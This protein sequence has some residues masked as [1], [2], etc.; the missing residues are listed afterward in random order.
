[1]LVRHSAVYALGR[2]GPGL[3]NFLALAL[4][5]RLLTPE[6]YGQYA[7]VLAGLGLVQVIGFQWLALCLARFLPAN[8][9]TPKRL[10]AEIKF[11][12]AVLALVFSAVGFAIMLLWPD[13]VWQRLLA[14]AVPL[15]ITQSW[16]ELNLYFASTTLNPGLYGRMNVIKSAVSL[17]VGSL[18]AWLGLGA[19]S[20]LWGLLLGTNLATLVIGR[21]I[22][23]D[24]KPVPPDPEKIKTLLA[25]G[26]PLAA[27]FALTW[28]VSSSDRFLLG[29]LLGVESAGQYA[30]G[31]DLAQQS[32][33]TLLM[34]VNLAA[35]PLVVHALEQDGPEAARRQLQKN[36]TAIFSLAFAASVGIAVLAPLLGSLLLGAE[37][38]DTAVELLPWVA[39]A[40]ALS[41]LKS[42]YFDTAFHLG[43][44]T[45]KLVWISI[46]AALINVIFNLVLIPRFGVLGS[47]YATILTYCAA[48][49]GSAFLGSRYFVMPA[50]MPLVMPALII[51]ASTAITARLAMYHGGW[52]G[53]GFGL[54]AGVVAALVSAIGINLVGI[55]HALQRRVQLL[56]MSLR[57]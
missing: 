9:D 29:W 24:I 14:L 32:I 50:I 25:F 19:Y 22:W 26:I 40:A 33:G 27:N 10:L 21:S 20:P 57:L 31:Y 39:I 6:E 37:Y 51:S 13:Q 23:Q 34:I 12:F 18:L 2:G 42:Y 4:Y 54:L 56:R 5:T 15:L 43:H 17:S 46:G 30:V 16:F 53:L 8:R 44:S 1:L 36:G 28:I 52:E 11:L 55:R 45:I 47:A 35:F 7:L 48:M 41:G 3:I 38:G 49:A